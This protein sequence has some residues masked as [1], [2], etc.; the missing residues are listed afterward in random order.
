MIAEFIIFYHITNN[1]T[2]FITTYI[3]N[4]ITN[5]IISSY[6][7]ILI[8]IFKFSGIVLCVY[9]LNNIANIIHKL[10]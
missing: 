3:T 4:N 9:M 1:I 7:L 10:L 2:N 5:F 8:V 6:S